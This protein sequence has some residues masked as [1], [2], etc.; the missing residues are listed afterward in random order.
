M[1]GRGQVSAVPFHTTPLYGA[2]VMPPHS[3]PLG[4][5]YVRFSTPEQKEGDSLRR[6]TEAAKSWCKRNGVRLD[7]STT[8][9]DLGKSAYLGDHRK[10]PDRFAL[11]AFLQMV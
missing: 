4:F 1:S 6:Q 9:H 11:A 5:S 2:R 8:L 3:T 10:N 7:E